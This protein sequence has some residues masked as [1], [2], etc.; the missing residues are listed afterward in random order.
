M[1]KGHIYLNFWALSIVSSADEGFRIGNDVNGTFAG[2]MLT[3]AWTYALTSREVL[4][5]QNNGTHFMHDEVSHAHVSA[6][7]RLVSKSATYICW[8]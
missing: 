7:I 4:L 3:I 2:D 8:C 1:L 5:G 6:P